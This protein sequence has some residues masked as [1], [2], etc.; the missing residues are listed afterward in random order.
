MSV[1]LVDFSQLVISSCV[2][3]SD[4]INHE[5]TPKNLIKHIIINQLLEIK[6]KL[7]GDV[8]LCC[9]SKTYWRRNKFSSY[10]GHRKH[11]KEDDFL[12]WPM[13]YEV[14][15]E[16]KSE[17]REHFPYTVLDVDGAE[18]D[19]IIACLAKY[20]DENE[21]VNTGLVEEPQQVVISSTDKDF[22]QLLKYRHVQI[23]H[24][25]D[26]K[27]VKCDNPKQFLIEHI[28]TGDTGDNISNVCTGDWWA[29]ARA[30]NEKT[31][32][33]SFMQARLQE[34]YNKGIDG[35][36]N[37]DER[38]NYLR[39][40]MLIDF[41]M[42]PET[43]YNS[44]VKEYINYEIAGDRKSVFSYLTSHRMKLLMASIQEF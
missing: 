39:N 29:I 35:C 42:I 33:K 43:V 24:N 40:E 27:Y 23:W 36:L 37:E 34:F 12:D 13:I 41:D 28:C 31:R 9:D 2:V 44:I 21:L 19:D 14:M 32:Q 11:A 26:K 15:D 1:I 5:G 17:F 18:A 25:V 16:M 7:K 8:I 3:H 22:K 30:N 4:D 20:F 38:K 10:K 6:K